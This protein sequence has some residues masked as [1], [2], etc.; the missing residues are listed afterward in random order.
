MRAF[1]RILA[2][3]GLILPSAY[4]L[5]PIPK[6]EYRAR[7][8]ALADKLTGGA[9]LLFAASQPTLDFLP[10]RQE[11]DFYYLTGWNQPGAAI[12]LIAPTGPTDGGGLLNEKP[13]SAQPYRAI[14]FLPARDLRTESYTGVRID[15]GDPTAMATSGFSEVMPF[16]EL[17]AVLSRLASVDPSRMQN[18]WAEPSSPQAAA[19]VA[20]TAMSLG[21]DAVPP[22][23]DISQLTMVLRAIKSPAE[24]AL[25]Q[26]TARASVA[27]Q[28]AAIKAVH[29][30]VAERT[31][32]GIVLAKLMEQG[33]ER[34]AYSPIVAAGENATTL[35]YT[36]ETATLQ[37]GELLLI[38]AAGQCGNYASD[39]T[40]TLPV[41]GKFSA[42]Q[43]EIYDVV[44]GA[45]RAA[46]AAFVPGKSKINDPQHLELDSLDRAAFDYMNAHGSD[47]HGQPLGQYMVHGIG[48]LV[49]LDVHDPWDYS[50]PLEQ[51]MVF[52]IEPGIYLPEEKIGIRIEDVFYVDKDGKLVDLTGAPPHEAAE[53]ETLM[54]P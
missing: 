23:R 51:G 33:C 15:A 53:I 18:I 39:I 45:Q 28:V 27:A 52:T 38:D 4:A 12:L 49:G 31:I 3:L 35:H 32:A 43:R 17:P 42:R 26:N 30:G 2:I 47:L 48:H 13:R 21:L 36:D 24:L 6:S 9:A 46:I 8:E 16:V 41:S 14:L 34:Q 7:R 40:R 37:S 50:K 54:R 5:D 44:L 1:L 25:L 11:P 29:P 19:V 20:V 22:T 10:Y